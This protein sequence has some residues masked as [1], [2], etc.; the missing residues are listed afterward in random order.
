MYCI[1]MHIVYRYNIHRVSL[2]LL[3]LLLVGTML[4]CSLLVD[5]HTHPPSQ[6]CTCID[7]FLTTAAVMRAT[8]AT[9]SLRIIDHFVM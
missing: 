5:T 9:H 7:S 3:L 6:G 8:L 4:T 1:T 2:L